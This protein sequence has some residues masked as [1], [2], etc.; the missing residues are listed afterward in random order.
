MYCLV[1][2]ILVSN[3]PKYRNVVG[4]WISDSLVDFFQCSLFKKNTLNFSHVENNMFYHVNIMLIVLTG[5]RLNLQEAAMFPRPVSAMDTR[6]RHILQSYFLKIMTT[7][8]V[9][10]PVH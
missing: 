1:L 5:S 7:A 6:M 3:K 4:I 2:Y 8:C 9:T 10:N